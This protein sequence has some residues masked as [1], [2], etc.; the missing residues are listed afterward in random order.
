MRGRADEDD[1]PLLDVG[2]EGVLLRFVE[3]MNFIHEQNRGLVMDAPSLHGFL[4]DPSQLGHAADHCGK[5]HECRFRLLSDDMGQGR[6]SRTG[7]TP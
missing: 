6:F 4:D 5:R 7:R 1:L 2:Q 3:P